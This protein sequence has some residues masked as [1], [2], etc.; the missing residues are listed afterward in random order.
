M[1]YKTK[2]IV[3]RKYQFNDSKKIVNL[4]TR[5]AGKKSFV[6]YENS[7]KINKAVF[8]PLFVLNIAFRDKNKGTVNNF[9]DVAIERPYVS[10]PYV[11]EKT[12]IAFFIAEILN[13]II[14][15]DFVDEQF[16]DFVV[17][18]LFLLDRISKPANF[19]IAFLSTMT[20]FFGIMPE[21]NLSEKNLFFDIREGKFQP[22]FSEN[23]CMDSEISKIFHTF[24][25]MGMNKFDE[26]VLNKR[27]RNII[28]KK[29]IAFYAYNY[30]N[31]SD[32]KSIDVLNQVFL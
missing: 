29:I 21:T 16:F 11:P 22:V 5:E 3:F 17:E 31:L 30:E 20:T 19:H 1:V 14:K 6:I 8:Q 10:I 13:K 12:A 25:A 7:K 23:Y 9:I 27:Q 4:L 24:L 28:I 15:S 2:A 18:A 32:L 26:I